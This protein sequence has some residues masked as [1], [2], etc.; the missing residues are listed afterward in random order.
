LKQ[1]VQCGQC[2]SQNTQNKILSYLSNN[3]ASS[4]ETFL[5]SR[6]Y[7]HGSTFS[8]SVVCKRRNL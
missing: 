7:S 3:S 6:Y 5:S 8:D 4:T 1:D 2:F